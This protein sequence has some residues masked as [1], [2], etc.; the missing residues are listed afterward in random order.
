M[1]PKELRRIRENIGLTQVQL[2]AFTRVTVL[3]I[4]RYE[5]GHCKIPF[6]FEYYIINEFLMP[7]RKN[8]GKLNK[9][10]EE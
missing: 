5:G 10:E 1:T 6:L 9:G 4:Q 8:I 2:A 3:T 7:R